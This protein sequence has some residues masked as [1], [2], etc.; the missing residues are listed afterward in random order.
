MTSTTESE[1]RA[2]RMTH[3]RGKFIVFDGGEGC[4]KSTQVDMLRKVLEKAGVAPDPAG[5]ELSQFEAVGIR[6]ESRRGGT[7]QELDGLSTGR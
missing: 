7:E 2:D 1:T 3:L 4:G 6:I 5:A